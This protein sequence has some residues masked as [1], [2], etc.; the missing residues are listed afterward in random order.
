MN[1][2]YNMLPNDLIFI[3]EDYAK[4]TTNHEKVLSQFKQKLKRAKEW[5]ESCTCLTCLTKPKNER[6]H[7]STENVRLVWQQNI[8]PIVSHRIDEVFFMV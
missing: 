1:E 8:K 5:R 7:S 4:D 2:L 6:G 3:I